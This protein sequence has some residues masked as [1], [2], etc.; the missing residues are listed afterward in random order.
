VQIFH[1]KKE[2][3]NQYHYLPLKLIN[4]HLQPP[5]NTMKELMFLILLALSTCIS[6][7]TS[8]PSSNGI[9]PHP[10]AHRAL[11][12]TLSQLVNRIFPPI[13]ILTDTGANSTTR[14]QPCPAKESTAAMPPRSPSSTAFTMPTRLK[15]AENQRKEEEV[16]AATMLQWEKEATGRQWKENN[17][18]TTAVRD[19]PSIPPQPDAPHAFVISPPPATNLNSLL[20]GQVG[21]E[22]SGMDTNTSTITTDSDAAKV[23]PPPPRRKQ[24]NWEKKPHPTN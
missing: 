4:T 20:S 16:M 15:E 19:T 10:H 2:N 21:Q 11:S 18:R 6:A 9:N 17:I 3:L 12:E 7:S 24:K 5:T 13:A 22:G 8:H 23:L 1:K 14:H